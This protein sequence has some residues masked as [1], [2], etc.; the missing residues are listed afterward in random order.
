MAPSAELTLGTDPDPTGTLDDVRALIGSSQPIAA[1]AY[2]SPP[3][4]AENRG[5]YQVPAS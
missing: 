4:S 3:A 1:Q 2:T 5:W